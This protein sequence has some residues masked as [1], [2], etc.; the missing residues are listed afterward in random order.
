MSKEDLVQTGNESDDEIISIPRTDSPSHGITCGDQDGSVPIPLLMSDDD[1]EVEDRNKEEEEEEEEEEDTEDDDSVCEV[2]NTD[3]PD[4]DVGNLIKSYTHEEVRG[5]IDS[6]IGNRDCVPFS[7]LR[8]QSDPTSTSSSLTNHSKEK[9]EQEE[10]TKKEEE[11]TRNPPSLPHQFTSPSSSSSDHGSSFSPPPLLHHLSNLNLNMDFSKDLSR[12]RKVYQSSRHEIW[13]GEVKGTGQKVAVKTMSSHCLN[14][15]DTRESLEREYR[16]LIHLHSHPNIVDLIGGGVLDID[17]PRLG[18]SLVEKPSTNNS[19]SSSNLLPS[20]QS[21]M[22]PSVNY[23]NQMSPLSKA[24][25][26]GVR[27]IVMER[28]RWRTL[29]SLFFKDFVN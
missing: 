3:Q 4:F 14:P 19:S 11:E 8:S 26:I 24:V 28:L 2:V 15:E 10:G 18:L 21:D 5:W 13:F 29:S 12:M 6:P 22:I 23:Q 27:F 16:L 1:E 9:E 25:Q 17:L 20:S 7:P